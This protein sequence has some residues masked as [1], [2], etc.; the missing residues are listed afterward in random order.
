MNSELLARAFHSYRQ[1]LR[2]SD[3]DLSEFPQRDYDSLM[4]LGTIG[5]IPSRDRLP[6]RRLFRACS[7]GLTFARKG[8]LTEAALDY[9]RAGDLL[10]QLKQGSMLGYLVA[11]STYGSG[12]AYLDFRCG[13][14]IAARY[15]LDQAMDA[16]LELEIA[17]LPVMQMH[18]IQ[19]GH[20]I[21]R[22][23]FH[24]ASRRNAVELVGHLTSY[25]ESQTCSLP[26]HRMW[27]PKFVKAVARTRL[28]AMIYQVLG[29]TAFQIAT[30]H[31][32]NQ[33]W[34]WLINATSLCIEPRLAISPQAQYALRAQ[35]ALLD[36]Q[37]KDYLENLEQFFSLG[38]QKAPLLWY[39]LMAEFLDFCIETGT[40]LSTQIA[41]IITRDS[42]K[43]NGFP[44]RLKFRFQRHVA[45][46]MPASNGQDWASPGS[47]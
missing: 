45:G 12:I 7:Y 30:S 8:Q 29:E 23:D 41:E 13:Q 6:L 40:P 26:Y 18:R 2:R 39:A 36:R 35:A 24:A 43:W 42:S 1:G 25:M 16:D 34:R 14:P 32:P 11:L 38:I 33:E 31:S 20:N 5:W 46:S 3:S 10:Q 9:A 19:Q 22:M 17:G 27:R 47:P 37:A 15:Q 28:Q 4:F 21:S 44:E